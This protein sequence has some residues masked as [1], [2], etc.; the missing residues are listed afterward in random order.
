MRK[1]VIAIAAVMLS[2]FLVACS[3][4]NGKA[5]TVPTK[6]FDTWGLTFE[7]PETWNLKQG[8]SGGYVVQSSNDVI[9]SISHHVWKSPTT[10]ILSSDNNDYVD[11]NIEETIDATK[12]TEGWSD[13]TTGSPTVTNMETGK[14]AKFSL[15]TTISGSRFDGYGLVLYQGRNYYMIYALA[16]KNADNETHDLLDATVDSMKVVPYSPEESSGSTTSGSATNSASSSSSKTSTSAI[17]QYAS[18]SAVASM[19]NNNAAKISSMISYVASNNTSMWDKAEDLAEEII[20]SCDAAINAPS[21]AGAESIRDEVIN[22]ANMEKQIS[23]DTLTVTGG[24]SGRD[25]AINEI[26]DLSTKIA[27]LQKKIVAEVNAA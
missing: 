15:S 14:K 11:K 26:V 3:S 2:L 24:G 20:A 10:Y 23:F 18:Q 9:I 21:V 13:I 6:N 8:S 1:I 27:D 17:K 12:K 5:F 4:T 19:I 22:L 7:Y 16:N 25:A